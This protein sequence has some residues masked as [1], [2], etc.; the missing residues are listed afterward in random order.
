MCWEIVRKWIWLSGFKDKNE[1]QLTMKSF[2]QA[3]ASQATV[4]WLKRMISWFRRLLWFNLRLIFPSCMLSQQ[5][6][7][8][9][10]GFCRPLIR[11]EETVGEVFTSH[12]WAESRKAHRDETMRWDEMRWWLTCGLIIV[13]HTRSGASDSHYPTCVSIAVL[14]ITKPLLMWGKSKELVLTVG[15]A[16][17]LDNVK[18]HA[19]KMFNL[20]KWTKWS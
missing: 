10:P 19:G 4:L 15:E 13:V 17:H 1:I 18:V 11:W 5:L 16:G 20:T 7:L 14:E 2:N 8:R 3:N 6:T 12:L 9:A